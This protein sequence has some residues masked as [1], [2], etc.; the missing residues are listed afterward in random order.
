MAQSTKRCITAKIGSGCLMSLALASF[1][2]PKPHAPAAATILFSLHHQVPK[3]YFSFVFSSVRKGEDV[4]IFCFSIL[5]LN[6]LLGA[7]VS[8]CSE[9]GMDWH[10]CPKDIFLLCSFPQ[11]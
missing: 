2:D 5:L 3:I 9:R 6:R 1:K 10:F 7:S 11:S 4:Y 8:E